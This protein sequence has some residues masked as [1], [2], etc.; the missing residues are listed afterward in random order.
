MQKISRIARRSTSH[1]TT[2]TQLVAHSNFLGALAARKTSL[3][4]FFFYYKSVHDW[5][6]IHVLPR[7]ACEKRTVR[8]ASG[9]ST[10]EKARTRRRGTHHVVKRESPKYDL[11]RAACENVGKDGGNYEIPAILRPTIGRTGIYISEI[12]NGTRVH[13]QYKRGSRKGG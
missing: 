12:P 3:T 13:R 7:Y 10:K 5:T 4:T 8:I 11:P 1:S 9:N 6:C 2:A